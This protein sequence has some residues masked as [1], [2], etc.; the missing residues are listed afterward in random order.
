MSG[1]DAKAKLRLWLR[2]LACS[3][4]IER[5]VRNRLRDHGQTLPRFDCLAALERAPQGLTMGELS[6]R[7]RVSNGNVTGVVDRLVREGLVARRSP[8]DDRR[9]VLISLTDTGRAAFAGLAGEH[10]A[11]IDALLGGL[12]RPEIDAL[13]GLLQKARASVAEAVRDADKE[14]AA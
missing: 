5:D 4:D 14:D 2:L 3:Q 11:W 9:R 1:E 12:S 8:P 10:E 13:T 7:L 6:S